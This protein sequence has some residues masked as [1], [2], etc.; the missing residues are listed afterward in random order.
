[1]SAYGGLGDGVSFV[2]ASGRE[3]I[4][5]VTTKL[6]ADLGGRNGDILIVTP[7]NGGPCGTAGLNRRLH[8]K[9]ASRAPYRAIDDG[10]LS[11]VRRQ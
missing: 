2:H 11:L 10:Q 1:M 5:D 6:Y 9:R 3:A 4:A 7:V 8:D